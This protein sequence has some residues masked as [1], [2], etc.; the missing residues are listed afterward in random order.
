MEKTLDERQS[1]YFF[2]IDENILHL[3]TRVHLLNTMT[4]EERPMRQQV[5][6]PPRR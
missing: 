4:G 2:D 1:F 5:L 6:F 3:P